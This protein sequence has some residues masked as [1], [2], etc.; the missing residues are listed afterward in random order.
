MATPDDP[1]MTAAELA[2]GVLD[3]EERAAALRRLLADRAFAQEVEWWRAR[4]AGLYGTWPA[5]APGPALARRVAAIPDGGRDAGARWR[6]A[7]TVISLAAAA[8]LAIIVLRPGPAPVGPAPAPVAQAAPALIAVVKPT[9]GEPFGVV[10]DPATRQV[11]LNGAVAVPADRDA[12]LWTIGGDGVPHAAGLLAH[13]SGRLVL[14]R[15]LAVAAGTTLAI[16]IEP[17]GGSPKPTPTGPVVASG[18]LA[19]I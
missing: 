9:E 3:G 8:M 19:A 12:Q 14:A 11:R 7:T 10:F 5:A 17:V 2:L 1:D 6:W 15:G 13:G 16:S 18:K 4:L